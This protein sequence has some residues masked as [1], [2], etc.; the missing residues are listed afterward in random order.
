M[1]KF[2]TGLVAAAIL[3]ISALTI[4]ACNDDV[5]Y[6]AT[7]RFLY[8]VNG[9]TSWSETLQEVEVNSTYY[10]AVEMQ[11]VQSKETKSEN[12]IKAD[13]T[14]PNTNILDCYLD[15]HP[16][17]S[18]TGTPDPINNSITYTFDVVAGTSPAKFR[19]IFE[20]T[21]LAEG[22]ASIYVVYDDNVNSSWD[23]TGTIKYVNS[24]SKEEN[25]DDLILSSGDGE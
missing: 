20:C 15:D 1:K 9:G 7:T 5:I 4:T 23:A 18:I 8:S 24:S 13:I 22:K 11:V 19:V 12:I 3:V 2:L 14:I 16:G 10:L 25:E 17:I 21:P 6:Q